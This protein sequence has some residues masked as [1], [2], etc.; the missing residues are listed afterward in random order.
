MNIIPHEYRVLPEYEL[1]STF[2]GDK[3][4]KRSG[5][6]LMNHIDEGLAILTALDAS[7]DALRAF[8]LHPIVQNNEPIDVSWSMGFVLASEY[9]DKANAYLCRPEN[10]WIDSTEH[11]L[12]VVGI[13]SRQ[14][15]LMLLADKVQNQ[16]DFNIHHKDYHTRG[17]ELTKYFNIW[18]QYLRT[19]SYMRIRSMS[20]AV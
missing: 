11:V 5:V 14:C 10:D 12:R 1:I 8:C 19:L 20:H 17:H 3:T 9:R 16:K 15:Q 4:A 18:I 13:P 2:Y 7:L 6:P